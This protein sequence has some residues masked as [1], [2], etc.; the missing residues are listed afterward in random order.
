MRNQSSCV[1]FADSPELASQSD[2]QF[3]FFS[4]SLPLPLYKV[5]P[6]ALSSHRVP[7]LPLLLTLALNA[8]SR[9]L[10][11]GLAHFF[12]A[13]LNER[14]TEFLL[15]Y[16]DRWELKFCN[17]NSDTSGPNTTLCIVQN[18]GEWCSWSDIIWDYSPVNQT[19]AAARSCPEAQQKSHHRNRK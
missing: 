15:F 14:G 19:A 12:F 9:A 18:T 1:W 7:L 6:C 4:V 2:V 13:L 16:A 11:C 3:S 5:I 8:K 10:R 17:C